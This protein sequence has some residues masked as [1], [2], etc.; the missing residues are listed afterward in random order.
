MG[1]F[2][3]LRNLGRA[4]V[5]AANDA[6]ADPARDGKYDIQD[7]KKEIDA[8]TTQI[9]T[10]SSQNKINLRTQQE[11]QESAGRY[12][13]AAQQ[14]AQQGN[15]EDARKLLMQKKAATDKAAGYQTDID[16]NARLVADMRARRDAAQAKIAQAESS[17]ARVVA[18]QTNNNIRQSLAKSA[19]TFGGGNSAL[20]RL[21]RLNKA[22]L[23]NDSQT[24]AWED[25]EK[26]QKSASGADLLDK[27]A[28][29]T[30]GVE[31]ELAALMSSSGKPA[32]PPSLGTARLM[33]PS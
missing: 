2:A 30:S 9:V 33:P 22:A 5:D 16:K 20:S 11:A 10:L 8:L 31:D 15:E 26:D 19:A 28:S 24:E 25:E 7:A 18:A 14:A 21:D 4:Q 29:A 23:E 1:I 12:L 13:A 6:L 27:Y 17:L 3:T 32:L